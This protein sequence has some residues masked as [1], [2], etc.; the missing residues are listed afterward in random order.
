MTNMTLSVPEELHQ[1]MMQH[2]EFK[3]S[4]IARQAF[5]K[6]ITETE[7]M[8]KILSKSELTEKDAEEIGNKIKKEI[9]KRFDK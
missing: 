3:W 2:P 7:I 6:K 5:E 4:E 1:K 9:R 8:G